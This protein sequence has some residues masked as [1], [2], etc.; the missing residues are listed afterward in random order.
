MRGEGGFILHRLSTLPDPRF[1]GFSRALDETG[2][3]RRTCRTDSAPIW[4]NTTLMTRGI[5]SKTSR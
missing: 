1:L 3:L 2:I 4:G 5:A